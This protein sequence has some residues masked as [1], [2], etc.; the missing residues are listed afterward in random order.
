MPK[1]YF[2]EEMRPFHQPAPQT[3]RKEINVISLEGQ[4]GTFISNP[5]MKFRGT[6]PVIDHFNHRHFITLVEE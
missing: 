4:S 3:E 1:N 6:V 5:K 2:P